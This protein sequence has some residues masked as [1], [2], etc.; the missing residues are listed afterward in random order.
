MTASLV[1]AAVSCAGLATLLVLALRGSGPLAAWCAAFAGVLLVWTTADAALRVTGAPLWHAVDVTTSPFTIPIGLHLTASFAGRTRP[2]RAALTVAWLWFGALSLANAVTFGGA[3]P[4]IPNAPWTGAFLVG[5]ACAA[6]LA[7]RELVRV[8]R[9]AASPD[10][11]ARAGL[12]L[13]ALPFAALFGMTDLVE[14]LVPGVPELTPVGVLGSATA[15]TVVALRWRLFGRDLSTAAGVQA[16]ALGATAVGAYLVAAVAL[17]SSAAA[18]VLVLGVVTAALVAAIRH[19]A[20]EAAVQRARRVELATLG[21]ASAQMAHDLK[22]PLAA[23]RGGADVLV[24]E[25]RRRRGAAGAATSGAPRH[26]RAAEDEDLVELAQGIRD[27]AD[28]LARMVDDYR[29][30][31]RVEPAPTRIDVARWLDATVASVT[32]G[33]PPGV[34]IATRMPPGE[35]TASFDAD[36]V[37]Q[38][39]D[40]LA[41]NAFEALDGR[42]GRVEVAVTAAEHGGRRGIAVRVEDDGPGM[43]PRTRALATDDFFTTKATG[44]GL[45]LAFARRV[46][47]AHGGALTLAP[48]PGGGTVVT[49]WLPAP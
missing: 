1:V 34:A 36:L 14:S 5:I 47:E 45:G 21:R 44:S 3:P 10:E 33:A 13:V 23:I 27:D 29:R 9:D 40:N 8:R 38:V 28:R 20:G 15:T 16:L 18:L 4:L 25:L 19:L 7:T 49:L 35:M 22:N 31:V 41:R 12:L 2:L 17:A 6:A 37:S 11:R 42:G 43:D 24:E 30:F 39:V 48:R 32:R 46:A 26:D